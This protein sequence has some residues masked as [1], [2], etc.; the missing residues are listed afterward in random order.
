MMVA[1]MEDP[2]FILK[3]SADA[4]VDERMNR[5]RGEMAEIMALLSFMI[6]INY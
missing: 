1:F 2:S 5:E 4:V 3:V 6:D